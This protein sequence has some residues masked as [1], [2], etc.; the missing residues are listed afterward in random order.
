MT[1]SDD[2]TSLVIFLLAVVSMNIQVILIGFYRKRICGK[3]PLHEHSCG[4]KI[5]E[6]LLIV[7]V[8][9]SSIYPKYFTFYCDWNND[10]WDIFNGINTDKA[11]LYT[12]I[13]MVFGIILMLI[14]D[15]LMVWTLYNLGRMRTVHVSKTETELKPMRRQSMWRGSRRPYQMA[16]HPMYTALMLFLIGF[17]AGIGQWLTWLCFCCIFAFAVP[18]IRNEERLLLIQQFGQEYIEY[19]NERGTFCCCTFCDCGISAEERQSYIYLL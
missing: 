18:R 12:Y 9:L 13:I 8:F 11:K 5:S 3:T 7:S 10:H 19:M 6:L 16:R 2:E 1:W 14:S 17:L 15:I 4:S